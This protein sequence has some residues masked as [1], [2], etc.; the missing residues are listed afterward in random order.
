[1]RPQTLAVTLSSVITT[2][3]ACSGG[4]SVA[5]ATPTSALSSTR[6]TATAGG[7]TPASAPV[8]EVYDFCVVLTSGGVDCWGQGL[9]GEL[10]N[11]KNENSSVPVAVMGAG[12]NGTLSGV[13][14]VVA[15]G[16][17]YC[18]VLTSG[19]VDCWGSGVGGGRGPGNGSNIPVPV[20]GVG[21][22]GTLSG[23]RSVVAA[24]EKQRNENWR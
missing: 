18:A 13:K 21:G 4:G 6:A 12:G 3:V 7:L 2:L 22:R 5:K 23:V 20:E 14:S 24:R 16:G 19:G 10:G 1:M 15:A 9:N 8:G 11:G 17:G